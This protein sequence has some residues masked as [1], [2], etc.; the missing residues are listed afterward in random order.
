VGET[1]FSFFC[2]PLSL[3]ALFRSGRGKDQ[4]PSRSPSTR[5]FGLHCASGGRAILEADQG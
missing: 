2:P 1:P 5:P 3:R 4:S